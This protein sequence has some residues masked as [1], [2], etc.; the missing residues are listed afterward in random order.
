[1]NVKTCVILVAVIA[2]AD[3]TLTAAAQNSSLSSLGTDTAATVINPESG[4]EAT[5]TGYLREGV[6]TYPYSPSGHYPDFG[7]WHGGN[8]RMPYFYLHLHKP[9]DILS[10]HWNDNI[11]HVYDIQLGGMYSGVVSEMEEALGHKVT[12]HGI[13]PNRQMSASG[14]VP[15]E[16]TMTVQS[17]K[18]DK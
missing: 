11:L 13:F 12:L 5:L 10:D 9:V 18:V 6:I 1:M 16:L 7:Y 4:R 15:L 8:R 17:V 14:K 3:L 2:S